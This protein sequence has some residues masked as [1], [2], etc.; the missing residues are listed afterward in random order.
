[1]AHVREQLRQA[2]YN[3]LIA[4]GDLTT[5]VPVD[6]ISI[7]RIYLFQTPDI[8]SGKPDQFPAVNIIA[9]D[10]VTD[11]GF[12][13]PCGKYEVDQQVDIEI[14]VNEQ[15]QY[16]AAIDDIVVQVQKALFANLKLGLPITGVKYER[17]RMNV[18]LTETIYAA[19]VLTY[20]YEYRVNYAD[21][22]EFA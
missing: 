22:E 4:A 9:N 17:S 2:I 14:Y 13:T 8:H 10:D 12:I 20:T 5:I 7:E 15:Q 16:G 18:N 11:Q 19:R 6:N 21:P 1:M 3:T